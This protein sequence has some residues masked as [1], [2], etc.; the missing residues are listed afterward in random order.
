MTDHDAIRDLLAG[1][2]LTL[3]ADDIDGC[4][5]L[6]AEDGEFL[7]YGKALAGIERIRTMLTRAPRGMHLTGAA[8]IDARPGGA[9]VR[10]Q[11]LFVDSANHQLR[12]ALY[13]D[14][15]VERDGRWLFRRRRCRFIT[16]DGLC[17]SPPDFPG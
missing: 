15:L 5:A 7:V 16:A 17:D 8:V 6:F 12:P 13:D 1:Y 14:D 4:L 10:S 11:V 3:D 9:V 2:A